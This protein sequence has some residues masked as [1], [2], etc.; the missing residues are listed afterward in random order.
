MRSFIYFLFF[1]CF[2]SYSGYSQERHLKNAKSFIE[3]GTFD[4]ALERI[5]TYENSVGIKYESIYYRYLLQSRMAKTIAEVDSAI[6][7]LQLAKTMYTED[8][9][10][11]KKTSF[12]EDLQIKSR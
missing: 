1:F 9:D 10:E 5:V 4:K 2:F 8:S 3:K 11:K 12:C 7:L 6:H